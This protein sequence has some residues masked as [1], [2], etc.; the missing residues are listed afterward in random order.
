M[1]IGKGLIFSP[2]FGKSLQ[3]LFAII[4]KRKRELVALLIVVTMMWAKVSVFFVIAPQ[5]CG[6]V[7]DCILTC[8]LSGG[9][10]GG[11]IL[12]HLTHAYNGLDQ[13]FL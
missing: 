1:L 11:D 6:V 12:G 8:I 5:C 7:C 10:G 4:L 9:M 3:F 13:Y 2:N